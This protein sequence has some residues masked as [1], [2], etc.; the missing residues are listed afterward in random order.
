MRKVNYVELKELLDSGKSQADCSRHFLVSKTAISKAVRRLRALELPDSFKKLTDKKKAY[1]LNRIEGKSKTASAI[2]AFDCSTLD[3]AKALGHTLSKD[4]DIE[5]AMSDLMAQ[6]AIPK[7]RRIQ[8]LRE[9]IES[10]DLTAVSKGLDMSWKLDGSYVPEK[11]DHRE[12]S[13]TQV[14]LG[15]SNGIDLGKLLDGKED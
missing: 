5:V 13:F 3:S 9:L 12:I 15:L 2:E 1:V 8:K 4:P 10:P 14:N 6:E 11:H 7:R